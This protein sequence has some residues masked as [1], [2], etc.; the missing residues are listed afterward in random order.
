MPSGPVVLSIAY[1]PTVRYITKLLSD[2]VYLE[3][4]EN[5]QKQ[6]FRNRCYVYGA[7]GVQTLV[8][9]VIKGNSRTKI[10]DIKIDNGYNWQKIHWKAI[11]SAYRLSPY[12]EYYADE[13]SG[14]Y[15]Y[16]ADFLFEWDFA[17]L[18]TI[19][20]ILGVGTSIKLTGEYIQ[21][22][23]I[24]DY[25]SSIHPKKR[26]DRPDPFFK[27]VPYQQV[28]AGRHGFIPDL[29][30]IDV[31]FNEGPYALQIVRHSLVQS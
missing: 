8:I 9:P 21:N 12:F 25:R 5:Y 29:S 3:D 20:G 11:E 27:P 28:F 24:C 4:S 19:T 10:T 15:N 2:D 17:L 30:I 6:S 23:G 7:N 22:Y 1:L 31:I 26:L 13:L 14:F 16:R 18:K